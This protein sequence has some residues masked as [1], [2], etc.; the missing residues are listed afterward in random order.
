MGD[1]SCNICGGTE[2]VDYKTRGRIR[3]QAC[4]SI[5]RHRL[6]LLYLEKFANLRPGINVLH[7]APE[8]RIFKYI[9][10]RVGPSYDPRDLDVERYKNLKFENIKVSRLDLCKDAAL[11]PSNFYDLII[12]NHVLEH[13]PCNTTAVLFHLHRSLKQDGIHMFSIPIFKGRYE[14]SFVDMSKEDREKQFH[15]WDHLRNFGRDDLALTLG[16]VF[17]IENQLSITPVS[18]F[19]EEILYRHNIPQNRWRTFTGASLFVLRKRDL[20]L[21]PDNPL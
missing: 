16:M 8:R 21:Q 17:N 1:I 5:E 15:Q 12:H 20:L 9:A 18:L 10:E 11:L 13:L 3:C 19:G 14:E 2:F 6:F 7:I 4:G